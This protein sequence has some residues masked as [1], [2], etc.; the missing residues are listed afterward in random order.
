VPP[1]SDLFHFLLIK[2]SHYDDDGY[3][4]RW[5]RSSLPAN[6][7]ATVYGIA[8]DSAQRQALGPGIEIQVHALDETNSRIDPAT[9]VRRYTRKGAR[10]LVG[11]VGVQSNQFPRALDLAREFRAAGVPLVIGGFHVSGCL[12]MLKELPSDLREALALGVTLFAGELEGRLDGLLQEAAADRLQPIYN[13]LDALPDLT[14]TPTPILPADRIR[15][16]MGKRA[17][18]D[19]GRGCPFQCSFCTIINVQG[20]KSRHRDA[21][22]VERLIRA[23]AAQG[24][25]NFFISDDNFAR[26]THWEAIFDRLIELRESG[27]TITLVIQVDTQ[28]HRIPRFID[29]AARAGVT[30]V[31]LGLENINPD[32]LK[33]AQKG[34]NKITDYR[35][36]LQAWHDARV[37]TYAG[38]ILGFPDDTPESIRRDIAIIQNELPIDILEFFILTPLP[39]SLDHQ[40]L[41]EAGAALDPDMNNYDTQ[42]VTMDHPRMTRAQW[43]AIYQEAWDLYYSPAHVAT[44][45]RRA[46]RWGYDP[47]HMMGKLFAFHAPAVWERIHPLE[48]GLIRIKRRRERRP[49]FPIEPRPVFWAK[50]TWEYLKKYAGAYALHRRYRRALAEVLTEPVGALPDPAME[51]VTA[52]EEHALAI[53]TATAAAQQYVE[54]RRAR[55]EP[56][57][58][59]A[60][61]AMAQ[62]PLAGP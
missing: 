58:P 28:S 30:R 46:R 24:I 49:G 7:L 21:D 29:K 4:I 62:A 41:V 47:R 10:L 23:N 13:Y 51:P 14:G 15:L 20:R 55:G 19:A 16:T 56:R 36:M 34:Q 22:D 38:Y 42:H 8:L 35:T 3:V 9:L 37:V 61:E 45:L 11:M 1:A 39:G 53:F 44:V 43:A 12:A 52:G 17:S 5:W 18:F 48:G 40:R 57:L 32:S 6:S 27:M 31:F 50:I 59:G 33:G 25:S 54:R 60:V 2:P 26:N